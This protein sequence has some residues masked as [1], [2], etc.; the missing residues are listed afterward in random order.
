MIHDQG[1][2]ANTFAIARRPIYCDFKI[3]IKRWPDA[4]PVFSLQVKFAAGKLAR[5]V[6]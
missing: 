2:Q 4:G 6:V 5:I 3:N 1:R